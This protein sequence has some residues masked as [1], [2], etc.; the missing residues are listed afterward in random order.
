MEIGVIAKVY[1][2]LALA[3]ALLLFVVV[4]AWVREELSRF[5]RKRR[6]SSILKGK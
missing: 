5:W 3:V 4:Y 6:Q 1:L 2:I